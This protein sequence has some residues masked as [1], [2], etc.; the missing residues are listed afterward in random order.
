MRLNAQGRGFFAGPK[1]LMLALSLGLSALLVPVGESNANVT[2]NLGLETTAILSHSNRLVTVT[3]SLVCHSNQSFVVSV[4]IQQDGPDANVVG[5]G[6]TVPVA[7]TALPQSFAVQV[8]AVSP[9]NSTYRNGPAS[10]IVAADQ[11]PKT[12]AAAIR[13]GGSETITAELRLSEVNLQAMV[14]KPSWFQ[15]LQRRAD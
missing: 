2:L 10:I 9:Q 7:C 11:F 3:G 8:E 13:R 4:V 14:R 12:Q 5:A 1:R 15:G 6:N